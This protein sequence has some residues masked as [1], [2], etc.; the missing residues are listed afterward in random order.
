MLRTKG[1][2]NYIICGLFFGS[3]V[4]LFHAG[5]VFFGIVQ[6]IPHLR[7]IHVTLIYFVGSLVYLYYKLIIDSNL[8]FHP[9]WI[10]HF[11]PGFI[12]ATA[13]LLPFYLENVAFARFTGMTLSSCRRR[14][15][16]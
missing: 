14:Y 3:G 7:Y 9:N 16:G 5:I 6:Q 10:L 2:G 13:L 15:R 11:L 8:H 12:S 4:W 1:D